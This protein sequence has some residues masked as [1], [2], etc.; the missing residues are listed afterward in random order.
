M[1]TVAVAHSQVSHGFQY[2]PEGGLAETPKFQQ[3]AI[4]AVA[5]IE[6]KKI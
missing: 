1:G 3:D 6:L 4:F 2:R 5:G